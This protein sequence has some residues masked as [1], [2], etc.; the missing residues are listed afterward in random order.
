MPKCDFNESCTTLIEITFWHGYSP[1]NMLHIFRT[2]FRRNTSE[3]LLLLYKTYFKLLF[4][5]SGWLVISKIN[6][7]QIT[8]KL[9]NKQLTLLKVLIVEKINTSDKTDHVSVKVR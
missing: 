2:P 5:T 7:D 1:V 8:E 3:W 9:F 4:I 6:N